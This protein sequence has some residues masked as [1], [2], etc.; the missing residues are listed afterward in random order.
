MWVQS[1]AYK[2]SE[3]NLSIYIYFLRT[4]EAE[5]EE[6]TINSAH[7][8]IAIINLFP[9]ITDHMTEMY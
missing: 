8:E 1:L 6:S 7:D 4:E 5:I 2:T 3:I 9:A